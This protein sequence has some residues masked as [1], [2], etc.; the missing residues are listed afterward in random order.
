MSGEFGSPGGAWRSWFGWEQTVEGVR[1]TMCTAHCEDNKPAWGNIRLL[2]SFAK[3][4]ERQ[5]YTV[6][7]EKMNLKTE[8]PNSNFG[9]IIS[10]QSV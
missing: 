10:I 9:S 7:I 8:G 5:K 4:F 3:S 1:D 6:M 2:A